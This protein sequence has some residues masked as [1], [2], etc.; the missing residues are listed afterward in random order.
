MIHTRFLLTVRGIMEV[1]IAEIVTNARLPCLLTKA[2]LSEIKISQESSTWR[3][4][5]VLWTRKLL[6][7]SAYLTYH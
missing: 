1:R 5:K 2:I 6:Q 7:S 3:I 4:R